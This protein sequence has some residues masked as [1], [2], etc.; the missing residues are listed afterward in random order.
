M[1]SVSLYVKSRKQLYEIKN[2]GEYEFG[3]YQ[4]YEFIDDELSSYRNKE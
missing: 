2:Q 1:R 4:T 3:I